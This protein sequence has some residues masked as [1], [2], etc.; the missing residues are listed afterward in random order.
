M[1]ANTHAGATSVT[2]PTDPMPEHSPIPRHHD[3]LSL[4][5]QLQRDCS[6]S[7]MLAKHRLEI[8]VLGLASHTC[9]HELLYC[10]DNHSAIT[11]TSTRLT[12]RSGRDL[13]GASEPQLYVL[14][15]SELRERLVEEAIAAPATAERVDEA[16][17]SLLA[18]RWDGSEEAGRSDSECA[19]GETKGV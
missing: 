4:R 2:H 1:S 19:I 18:D 12:E 11:F 5:R 15:A 3:V 13:D 8:D 10:V 6:L 9:R 16:R 7:E 17:R 14:Q